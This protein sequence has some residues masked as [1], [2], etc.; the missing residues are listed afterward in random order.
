MHHNRIMRQ[1]E[2]PSTPKNG[3]QIGTATM[4]TKTRTTSLSSWLILALLLCSFGAIARDQIHV[5]VVTDMM[6]S[7]SD[8]SGQG[9]VIAAELAREDFLSAYGDRF[10]IKISVIDHRNDARSALKAI[11]D[12]HKTSPIHAL[13]DLSGHSIAHPMQ[14]LAADSRIITILSGNISSLPSR[15][16]CSPT[17]FYWGYDAYALGAVMSSQ[18]LKNKWHSWTLVVPEGDLGNALSQDLTLRARTT[19]GFVASTI[20]YVPGTRDPSNQLMT[21]ATAQDS[22]AI[23]IATIG[24]DL[25]TIIR[26][27]YELGLQQAEKGL[28]VVNMSVYDVRSLGIYT[29]KDLEF[30]VPFYW[31]YD[32]RTRDFSERFVQ[33]HGSVPSGNHAAV[34]SAVSHLLKAADLADTTEPQ[35]IAESM[36]EILVDDFFGRGGNIRNDGRLVH[37]MYW[38]RVKHPKDVLREW[39]YLQVIAEIPADA[40]TKPLSMTGCSQ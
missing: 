14:R 1:M 19:G 9:S 17:S 15:N 12:L 38:V 3:N 20:K 27:A 40:A 28:A 33:R 24:T 4:K 7:F 35:V 32:E 23:A 26:Y 39:D 18:I 30:A 6:G 21:A 5:A 34:Y 37:P 8:V 2:C 11:S 16:A 29:T 31:N 13:V 36:K 22:E 25:K 10:S